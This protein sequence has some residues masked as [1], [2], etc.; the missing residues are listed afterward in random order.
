MSLRYGILNILALLMVLL[1]IFNIYGTL[2]HSEEVVSEKRT[3]LKQEEKAENLLAGIEEGKNSGSIQSYITIAGKNIFSPERKD[4]PIQSQQPQG[5]NK[6]VVRPQIILY[7]VT[8]TEDFQSAS[9]VSPGR[10]LHEGER[11]TRTL[12]LGETIGEFKLAKILSDRI[13][14]EGQNDSFE[15]LLYDPKAEKRRRDVKTDNKPAVATIPLPSTTPTATSIPGI[16][17]VEGPIKTEKPTGPVQTGIVNSPLTSPTPATPPPTRGSPY[18]SRRV[19][20]PFRK[21]PL[22]VPLSATQPPEVNQPQ[23]TG[24]D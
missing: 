4:F 2:T 3:A 22:G 15:V 17:P 10:P 5:I 11:E 13:V 24:T 21:N 18:M 8:I 16:I 20:Y 6:P 7:G 12:K 14:V 19:P 1:L 23:E 9:I